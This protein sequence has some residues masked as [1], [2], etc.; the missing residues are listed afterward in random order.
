MSQKQNQM[1]GC[2]MENGGGSVGVV[3]WC[4][5][6]GDVLLRSHFKIEFLI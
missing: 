5:S 3:S 1:G 4:V 6:H 2:K